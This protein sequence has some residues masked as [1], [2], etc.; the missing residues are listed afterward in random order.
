[1]PSII[2][3]HILT[4][5]NISYA[6]NIILSWL[7]ALALMRGILSLTILDTTNAEIA[8][9]LLRVVIIFSVTFYNKYTF[10]VTVA[11]LSVFAAYAYRSLTGDY[12]SEFLLERIYNLNETWLFITGE[13]GFTPAL[14]EATLQLLSLAF[15]AASVILL[16]LKFSYPFIF[17][18]GAGVFLTVNIA[19]PDGYHSAFG[20]LLITLALIYIKRAKNSPKKVAALVPVCALALVLATAVPMPN[21]DESRRVLSELYEEAFWIVRSPFMPRYFSTHWLGFEQR[22]GTLGG[23]LNQSG[24][25][26]MWVFVDEP[27]YLRAVTK[28]IYTGRAWHTRH[29]HDYFTPR[30]YPDFHAMRNLVV[31]EYM[32]NDSFRFVWDWEEQTL[33]NPRDIGSITSI[34]DDELFYR[35]NVRHVGINIGRVR[36]GTIFTPPGSLAIQVNSDDYGLLQRGSDLRVTP[37]FSR[38]TTYSFLFHTVDIENEYIQ[39]MLRHSHRGFYERRFDEIGER[40]YM[41]EYAW[42]GPV[43]FYAGNIT[44]YVYENIR[45]PYAIYVYENYLS[46]PETLP[47]RVWE[48]A[49]AITANYDNNFDRAVAIKQ[50]LHTLSYTTTPGDL[51]YGHDFVDHFLFDIR[52]G[53]CTHFATA[54]SVMARM[55][56][57]PSR[58]NMGFMTPTYM[59]GGAFRVYGIHAHA[60]AELYFE[61]VGWVIF[62]ATPAYEPTPYQ[63]DTPIAPGLVNYW[64]E[65][66]I[67]DYYEMYLLMQMMAEQL[68]GGTWAGSGVVAA[69]PA[70]ERTEINI[71][72][73]AAITIVLAAGTYIFIR[74]AEEN[75]RHRVIHG[76]EYKESVLES[77]KGLIEIL[78]LY[79]LPMQPHES[80]IGYS[81][82]V[83]KLAPLGTM[84][85]R[86]AAEIFSRARYSQIEMNKDDADFVKKN[87]FQMHEKMKESGHRLRFFV[88]RY[89]VKLYRL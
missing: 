57:V 56:G 4:K 78:S 22:D 36:T 62:E 21:L 34:Y 43:P 60:W 53:Y 7:F 14:N 82:R 61:G 13:L 38:D 63:V 84:Q 6:L 25:F 40:I 58:Y 33:H 28:N 20:L 86:T 69:T 76:D 68:E 48:L 23:N 32:D 49:F 30:Y 79:G 52:H 3:K 65:M 85:L 81:K 27:V 5:K 88:H 73:L 45:I 59:S 77:F 71:L 66:F 8:G 16:R 72:M 46:L 67:Y 54:M 51:P 10:F 11:A 17:A 55:I 26:I 89:I 9:M 47:E 37:T 50:Y 39:N 31:M 2:K 29:E 75:R 24:E 80:A 19:H 74:K 87:Y 18:L 41:L 12:P 83:E 64:D 35:T 1:M 70:D 15:G 44:R 42:N